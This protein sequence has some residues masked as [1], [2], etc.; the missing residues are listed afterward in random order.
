MLPL[1]PSQ[2]ENLPWAAADVAG[3]S[4]PFRL[5]AAIA[6]AAAAVLL[7]VHAVVGCWLALLHC[8]SFCYQL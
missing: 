5:T 6:V 1:R 4:T 7:G 8:A 2:L 3:V